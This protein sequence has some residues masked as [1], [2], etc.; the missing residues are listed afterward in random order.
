MSKNNVEMVKR[1]YH[2]FN[3]RDIDGV[4]AYFPMMLLGP[5]AW[6]EATFMVVTLCATI[7]PVSGLS[8]V[9]TLS[10]WHLK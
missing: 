3:A 6:M 7:G 1:I 10:R 8:L 2:S 9:H 5:M 4:L